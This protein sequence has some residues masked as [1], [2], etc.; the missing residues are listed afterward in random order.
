[1]IESGMDINLYPSDA[2]RKRGPVV[3]L[4]CLAE[5]ACW[6]A[7]WEGRIRASWEGVGD[8]RDE[9]AE[10]TAGVFSEM[11]RA[12]L[13]GITTGIA[14]RARGSENWGLFLAS[15][16]WYLSVSMPCP[17]ATDLGVTD[18]TWYLERIIPILKSLGQ[19]GSITWE[20]WQG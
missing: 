8:W 12:S 10:N 6:D 13:R 9:F 16:E 5:S 4:Q 11:R 2:S 15:G 1:M 19:V 17:R 14:L 7:I 18:L 3:M 20:E